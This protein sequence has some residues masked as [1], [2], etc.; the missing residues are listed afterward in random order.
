[1]L[2]ATLTKESLVTAWRFGPVV[3]GA[4]NV[5][6]DGGDLSQIG[7]GHDEATACAILDEAVACG[8][9]VVDTAARYAAGSSEAII[10][11]WLRAR[12]VEVTSRVSVATKVAPPWLDH[13]PAPFDRDWIGPM[14]TG[15][16]Q[17][18]GVEQVAILYTHAPDDHEMRPDGTGDP[19]PV[20][21]TLEALEE[22]RE[23]G[24]CELLGASNVTADQ[25]TRALDAADRLGIRGYEVVQNPFNLL[26]I[27]AQQEVL[28]LAAERGLTYTSHSPLAT[29]ILTGKYAGGVRPEHS[30]LSD[31]PDFADELTPQSEAVVALLIGLGRRRGASPG[32]LALAWQLAHPDVTAI[33][34]GPGRQ[35]PHL[36]LV[37]EAL[38]LDGGPD[39]LSELDPS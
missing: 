12:P 19:T 34:V 23:A 5:G 3:L 7:T 21:D 9:T 20:E 2:S 10:G 36:A 14:L 8:I 18:L 6:G 38:A 28:D 1:M 29:G 37:T 17:R 4:G 11:R 39:L 22:Q 26:E 32:A 24:R 30:R 33:T 16:L 13:R 31:Q 25:L 27:Q 15:C 35:A